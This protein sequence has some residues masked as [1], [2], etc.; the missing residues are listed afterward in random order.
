M[1]ILQFICEQDP[2]SSE[3]RK[4]LI[5]Q[6][7]TWSRLNRLTTDANYITQ[8]HDLSIW[9]K[10]T[11]T[12]GLWWLNY[13]DICLSLGDDGRFIANQLFGGGTLKGVFKF[14]FP[15]QQYPD[16]TIELFNVDNLVDSGYLP[17]VQND[18]L[19]N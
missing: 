3:L 1:K 12:P 18:L 14:S 2:P 7:N 6:F 8:K 5:D 19:V 16:V 10:H 13:D 11:Q 4:L 17:V 9:K 15:E